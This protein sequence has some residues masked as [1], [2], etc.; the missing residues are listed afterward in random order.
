MKELM[1]RLFIIIAVG[2]LLIAWVAYPY[3]SI[4]DTRAAVTTT[5]PSSSSAVIAAAVEPPTSQ[6]SPL[7]HLRG[8][9]GYWRLAQ[10][11]A[12][13]W[14]WVSPTGKLEFLNTVTTVQPEQT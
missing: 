14:W 3:L 6:P 2:G 13:V 4:S 11:Q 7:I 10:D 5:Q 8:Q 9:A 12:G 1:R